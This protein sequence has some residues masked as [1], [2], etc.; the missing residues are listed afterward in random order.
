MVESCG[1]GKVYQK[2]IKSLSRLNYDLKGEKS[3]MKGC[4]LSQSAYLFILKQQNV[5]NKVL[6]LI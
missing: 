5:E 3:M 1:H 6:S 4:N 2:K